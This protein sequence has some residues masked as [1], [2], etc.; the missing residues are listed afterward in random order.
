LQRAQRI[1]TERWCGG[2]RV[3]LL[4][5]EPVGEEALADGGVGH[6]GDAEFAAGA[7]HLTQL[8]TLV[9]EE[10]VHDLV[11]DDGDAMFLPG[12]MSTTHF[13]GVAVGK[14]EGFEQSFPLT[15]SSS[16]D[17]I[18]ERPPVHRRMKKIDRAAVDT[19]A[20]IRG[21]ESPLEASMTV[22]P[23]CW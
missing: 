21:P 13:V 17:P 18:L 2:G 16:L 5:S 23:E 7:L 14:A 1:A 19:E 15:Y 6:D 20:P 22:P 11:Y 10:V 12:A 8:R 3:V 9:V 4:W